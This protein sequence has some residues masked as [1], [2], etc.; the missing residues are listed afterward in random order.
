MVR[1]GRIGILVFSVLLYAGTSRADPPSPELMSKLAAYAAHFEM[2]RT[3]AS[4]AVEGRLDLLDGN[5]KVDSTRELKAHV[6]ADGTDAKLTVVSYFEDGKDKTQDAMRDARASDEK[7]KKDRENGKGIKMPIRADQQARYVFDQVETDPKNPAYV[8]LTFVPK[9]RSD[10]TIEGSAWVDAADGTIVSAGF[11]LSRPAIFV[12]FVHV[13]VEFGAQ[14][15]L[16]PALSK[17]SIEGKGGILFFRKH[18][19]ASATLSDYRV[20]P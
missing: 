3:H 17:I 4:Y 7:S 16:G 15:S 9:E 2:Q 11:K 8:R 20:V 18:Y 10:D 19:R 13:S 5:G 1:V 6:D 14:T 12:D